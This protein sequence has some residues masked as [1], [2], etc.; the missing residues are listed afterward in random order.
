MQVL[1]K[2]F[3]NSRVKAFTIIEV[4][5]SMSI[6]FIAVVSVLSVYSKVFTAIGYDNDI[7]DAVS[8]SE[9][10]MTKLYFAENLKTA[11]LDQAEISNLMKGKV[12]PVI[13]KP[14]KTNISGNTGIIINKRIRRLDP[15]LADIGIEAII[16]E[17]AGS[18]LRNY[19]VESTFS[20]NYLE[21][22]KGANQ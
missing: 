22:I 7:Q 8:F 6:V 21:N 14:Y 9:G 1:K 11:L 2:T 20:E 3:I 18:K 17:K 15:L 19:Y 10:F 16:Q 4:L 13:L 5:I 12:F